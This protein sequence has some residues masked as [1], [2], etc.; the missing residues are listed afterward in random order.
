MEHG[1]KV[2]WSAS[3]GVC[4][5]LFCPH[6]IKI[7][8]TVHSSRA[9]LERRRDLTLLQLVPLDG[10]EKGVF[11]DSLAAIRPTAQPLLNIPSQQ[12]LE[13]VLRIATEECCR[14]SKTGKGL[15]L[16]GLVIVK[17]ELH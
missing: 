1:L 10:T 2:G 6:L 4:G 12:T 11:H 14:G 9:G 5:G 17:L 13:Q 7:F 15:I 3:R 16:Q 8:H